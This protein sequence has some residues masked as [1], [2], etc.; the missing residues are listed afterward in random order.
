MFQ[1]R[2]FRDVLLAF[3]LLAVSVATYWD[4]F[5]IKTMEQQDPLGSTGA[6]RAVAV[7]LA[8]IAIY[9]LVRAALRR[10]S[11]VAEAIDPTIQ[12]VQGE[13]QVRL[14]WQTLGVSVLYVL[15]LHFEISFA[16][17]T[18]VFLLV[19][20]GVLGRWTRRAIVSG[21][22]AGAIMAVG[23]TYLFTHVF[24]VDLP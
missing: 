18:F 9:L 20:T 12:T 16:V 4:S 5:Y 24:L 10:K 1:S 17:S 21:F 19:L 13:G 3:G 8:L 11:N 2:I 23:C 15:A 14:V 7:A 22:L 6:P